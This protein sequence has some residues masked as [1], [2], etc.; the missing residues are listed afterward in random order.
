VQVL[1]LNLG[2]LVSLLL[3][4]GLH[5]VFFS[6]PVRQFQSRPT[7]ASAA[8]ALSVRVSTPGD[9]HSVGNGIEERSSTVGSAP[10]ADVA[11]TP[12]KSEHTQP[13]PPDI[14]PSALLSPPV[15]MFALVASSRAGDGDYF[16]RDH[17][18]VGPS[19]VTDVFID[20]P[21]LDNQSGNHISELSLFINEEGKVVR[22]RVEGPALPAPLEEAARTAFMSARFSPGQV[23]GLPVRSRIRVE[24]SFVAVP[25]A[26]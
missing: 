17:L 15:P 19:P 14:P 3:A 8:K 20:Y 13:E 16:T 4:I 9:G 26:R 7:L 22:V 5:A 21:P 11:A 18:S 2:F 23:D 10:A 12:P 1:R 24:V 6:V 25:R